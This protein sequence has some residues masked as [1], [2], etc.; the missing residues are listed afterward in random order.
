MREQPTP[1]Q[2]RALDALNEKLRQ[3]W[4]KDAQRARRLSFRP[5]TLPKYTFRSDL[6]WFLRR[7]MRHIVRGDE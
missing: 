3:D 4:K 1:E 7:L 2:I 5:S 6:G